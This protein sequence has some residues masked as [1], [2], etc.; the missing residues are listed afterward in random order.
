MKTIISILIALLMTTL[1]NV[2]AQDTFKNVISTAPLSPLFIRLQV[3]YQRQ[4]AATIHVGAQAR[5]NYGVWPN[6]YDDSIQKNNGGDLT[7]FTRF[8]VNKKPGGFY[9]QP[10]IVLGYY[11]TG[12]SYGEITLHGWL[13][14]STEPAYVEP[15]SFFAWGF[16]VNVGYQIVVKHISVDI[17]PGVNIFFKSKSVVNPVHGYSLENAWYTFNASTPV[18][19]SAITIGYRF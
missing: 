17:S 11:N 1:M 2:Q 8:M 5:C 4:V 15:R 3:N 10:G 16:S 12:A 7:L 13:I 19:C 18:N 6:D 14:E 9:F